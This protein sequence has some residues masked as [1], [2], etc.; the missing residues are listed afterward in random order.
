MV[1]DCLSL[2]T[3]S[4]AVACRQT[5]EPCA[6]TSPSTVTPSTSLYQDHP[7]L[8][9][10]TPCSALPSPGSPEEVKQPLKTAITSLKRVGPWQFTSAE[11]IV[12]ASAAASCTMQSL[13]RSSDACVC[14]SDHLAALF[15]KQSCLQFKSSMQRDSKKGAI[16]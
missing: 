1:Q 6:Q 14:C 9:S 12:Q 16:S 2:L 15:Q 8:L 4:A 3:P 7:P 13:P 5:H 10:Q 11:H